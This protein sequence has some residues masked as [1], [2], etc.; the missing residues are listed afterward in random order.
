MCRVGA[1]GASNFARKLRAAQSENAHLREQ[2]NINSGRGGP[3][4]PR[5]RDGDVG[6]NSRPDSPS[7]STI[8]KAFGRVQNAFLQ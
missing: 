4:G 6:P 1:A 2:A 7:T 3:C 8:G 5:G